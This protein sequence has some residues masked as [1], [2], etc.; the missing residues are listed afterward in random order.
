MSAV[1]EI[2]EEVSEKAAVPAFPKR[3][4]FST[5]IYN[6]MVEQGVFA[7]N[8]NFELLNGDII[9]NLPKGTKHAYF[10]DL[11][12]DYFKELAGSAAIVRNQ[13]PVVLDDFSEPEPDIVL[14]RPPRE[15]CRSRYPAADDILLIVEVSDT[16]L[17]FDRFDRGIPYARAGVV[18]YRLVNI[19]NNTIEDYRDPATDGCQSKQTYKRGDSFLLVAFPELTINTNDFLPE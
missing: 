16:S 8:D 14:V 12:S 11:I 15:T 13:N 5:K 19:E 4:R 17:A 6:A 3:F 18:Q 10:N 2:I 9:D 1:I 7:E